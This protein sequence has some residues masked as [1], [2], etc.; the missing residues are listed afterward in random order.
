MSTSDGTSTAWAS[1]DAVELQARLPR[2]P[3]WPWEAREFEL[4]PVGGGLNNLN[5]RVTTR[6]GAHH[7]LKVPGAG[8]ELFV[9]RV[10]ANAAAKT[11]AAA[12]IAPPV[13]YF[14]PVSGI[15]MTGFLDGHRSLTEIEV[16]TT[17]VIFDVVRTLKKFHSSPLLPAARTSFD[18]IRESLDG[19]RS[20]RA[21]LP[22][23]VEE[24]VA[25]WFDAEAAIVASGFDLAPCHNDPNFPNFMHRPG[26]H[27]K[28]VDYEFAANNDPTFE[29]GGVLGFYGLDDF[30][31]IAL[32]EEY[33]GVYTAAAEARM[34]LM[35]VGLLTRFGIWALSFA[36]ARD[37]DYDYEKY[38]L[39]YFSYAS[40]IIRDPRWPTWLRAV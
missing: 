23:W 10:L 5:W 26:T 19:L 6:D 3:D 2:L 21:T 33:Y 20:A 39:V 9:D 35:T 36:A 40:A 18:V 7:F 17:D 4:A 28:L 32:L 24:V 1:L 38:G 16:S 31:R 27:L 22:A 25:A 34:W 37:A 11:A 13:E 15:E 29:V 8:T 30:T 12:G 14:D